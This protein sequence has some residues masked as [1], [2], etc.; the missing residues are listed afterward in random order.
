MRSNG[1]TCCELSIAAD[2]YQYATRVYTGHEAFGSTVLLI[3]SCSRFVSHVCCDDN[4]LWTLWYSW[5][6]T[7]VVVPAATL[8]SPSAKASKSSSNCCDTPQQIEGTSNNLSRCMFAK[9]LDWIPRSK[10]VVTQA[11]RHCH[12]VAAVADSRHG[13]IESI[14]SVERGSADSDARLSQPR[15]KPS[16]GTTINVSTPRLQSLLH[17]MTLFSRIS[18]MR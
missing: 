16:Q 6:I 2:L 12:I 8:S 17:K 15:L 18:A 5:P 14:D 7:A 1:S 11:L 4:M 10:A 13:M 9:R 3:K